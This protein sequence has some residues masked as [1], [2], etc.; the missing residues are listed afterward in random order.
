MQIK[1]FLFVS[2]IVFFLCDFYVH[3]QENYFTKTFTTENGLPHNHVRQ[4]NQ[5]ST[6]FLWIATW[7]GLSRY[8]GYDFRNYYHNP[9]DNSSLAYFICD[10]VL[11]DFQN[12]VWVCGGGGISKYNRETDNFT[13]FR[14]RFVGGMEL[15]K[16]GKL[17]CNTNVGLLRWNYQ[18]NCFETIKTEYDIK[19]KDLEKNGPM[20]IVFDNDNGL[21]ICAHEND[22]MLFFRCYEK[23]G[24]LLVSE[25]IGTLDNA[26]YFP[27]MSNFCR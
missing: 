11:V 6:G 18:L 4:I 9:S 5:D 22:K 27:V 25:F 20:N 16:K 14:Y 1:V 26:K 19:L 8:D 12:N 10:K 23:N 13:Q 17:W 3:G 7:D 2:V 24:V 21:W 15:D